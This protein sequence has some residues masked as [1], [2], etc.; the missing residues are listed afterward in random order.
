MYCF[1]LEDVAEVEKLCFRERK[2]KQREEK[3]W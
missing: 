3:Q 1:N 2:I